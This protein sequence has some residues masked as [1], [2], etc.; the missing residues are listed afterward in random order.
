MAKDM[1]DIVRKYTVD[2]IIFYSSFTGFLL[3]RLLFC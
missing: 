3:I 2:H 1:E